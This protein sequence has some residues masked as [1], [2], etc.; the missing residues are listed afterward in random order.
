MVAI[1]DNLETLRIVRYPDPV[2][3]RTAEPVESFGPALEAL[4]RRMLELM[5]AHDGVGL[6][7]PQVGLSLR[8]FVCNA[9]GELED[10][11]ICVN[12]TLSALTGSQEQNEGC[13]SI[14]H[15]TVAMRRAAQA[16]MEWFNPVGDRCERTGEGLLVRIWQ[17][18]IDHLNGRLI[19]DS[20]STTDELANRRAIRQL[21]D[22]Y[23]KQL[24]ALKS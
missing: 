2:L 16:T 1:P 19:I 13:L 23:R 20:M 17:H 3:M 7:A 15:V 11:L 18:E 8:L 4:G 21:R 12:P 10:D 24:R 5:R 9:T 22:D 6:A 14:P